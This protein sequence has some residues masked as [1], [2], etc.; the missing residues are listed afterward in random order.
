MLLDSPSIKPDFWALVRADLW[1]IYGRFGWGLLLRQLVQGVSFKYIFW[2]RASAAT[3]HG[4]GPTLFL[5]PLCRFF[6]RRYMFR[7]GISIPYTVNIGPG[8]YIG[9]FGCIV[10]SG[11]AEIGPNCNLSQGV[12]IGS[13]NRGAHR[14]AATL[15][16][17]VYLGPG[18]K[19]V[20]AVTIGDNVAVGANAVV[21]DDLPDNAVAVGI[22]AYVVS[23]EGSTGYVNRVDYPPSGVAAEHQVTGADG[24]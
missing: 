19:V 7:F 24:T 23:L 3:R 11:E 13:A 5:Y 1:R 22:P 2:M 15:G 14:G 10:V 9:H 21:V 17:N 18:A 20:G 16:R 8:L 12:T 4:R 6:Y